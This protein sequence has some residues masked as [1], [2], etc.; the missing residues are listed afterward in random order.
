MRTAVLGVSVVSSD[1]PVETCMLEKR[2][3]LLD[4]L[5]VTVSIKPMEILKLIELL[6]K[7]DREK[8]NCDCFVDDD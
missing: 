8:Y 4:N 5:W 6:K 7:C 2:N 3:R 1:V